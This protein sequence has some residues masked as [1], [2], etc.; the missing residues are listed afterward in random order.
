MFGHMVGHMV[1]HM[2]GHMLLHMLLHMCRTC[3]FTFVLAFV[4]HKS[5]YSWGCKDNDEQAGHNWFAVHLIFKFLYDVL[6]SWDLNIK[7]WV[8]KN[9]SHQKLYWAT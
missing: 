3:N 7:I 5:L 9:E 8:I 6:S 4:D 1:G 2:A